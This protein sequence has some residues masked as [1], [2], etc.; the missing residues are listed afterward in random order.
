MVQASTTH[1]IIGYCL[2]PASVFQSA[3]TW[4]RGDM[5][6]ARATSHV[7]KRI[8]SLFSMSKDASG[9]LPIRG[10][11]KRP[12]RALSEAQIAINTN[13]I[14]IMEPTGYSNSLHCTGS[15]CG[16]CN[17]GAGSWQHHLCAYTWSRRLDGAHYC[18][19]KYTVTHIKMKMTPN[20]L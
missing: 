3:R 17:S 9:H 19:G 8:V 20:L 5:N 1:H 18:Y 11:S 2:Q 16:R 13:W 15:S 7:G 14:C 12:L 6:G 10:S 4:K